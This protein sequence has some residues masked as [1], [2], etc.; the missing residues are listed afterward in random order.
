MGKKVDPNKKL[1]LT[2]SRPNK[3]NKRWIRK[4]NKQ[5]KKNNS[6]K[7][8][9][10]QMKALLPKNKKHKNHSLMHLKLIFVVLVILFTR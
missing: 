5:I 3:F 2:A 8:S 7:K 9:K 4:F 10:R 1:G 6:Y